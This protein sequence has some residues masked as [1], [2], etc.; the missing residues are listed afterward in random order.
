MQKANKNNPWYYAIIIHALIPYGNL[1]SFCL[2]VAQ[3]CMNWAPNEN[4]THSCSF[5]SL[6]C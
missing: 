3:G 4:R 2:D 1:P 5:A 6:P